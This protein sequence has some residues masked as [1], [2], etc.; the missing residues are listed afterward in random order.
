MWNLT[1]GPNGGIHVTD[2]TNASRTMLM[3]IEYLRWDSMLCNFFQIP[4]AI[5]PEIKSSA[6]IYG[7]FSEGK[8]KVNMK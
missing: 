5:L 6:E 3:N 2:A 1:G 4:A 7:R 8:L